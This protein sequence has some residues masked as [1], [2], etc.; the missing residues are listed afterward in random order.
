MIL[1]GLEYV[2]TLAGRDHFS[3]KMVFNHSG[4]IFFPTSGEHRDQTAPGIRYADNYKGNALAAMLAP[5]RIEVRYHAGYSDEEVADVLR[6]LLAR[7][8]L[9]FM[10]HWRATYQ[11]RPIAIPPG[12]A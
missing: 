11:G 4:A 12:H 8:E 6:T 1:L 7:P 3:A 5:G 9:E 2:Q 10:A